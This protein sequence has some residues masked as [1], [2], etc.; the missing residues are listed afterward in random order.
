MQISKRVFFSVSLVAPSSSAY[1]PLALSP[2]PCLSRLLSSRLFRGNASFLTLSIL[3][4]PFGVCMTGLTTRKPIVG[5]LDFDS[6][7][8]P[9]RYARKSLAE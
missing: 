2:C 8:V 4:A 3:F 5:V 1:S 9:G 6:G 7:M